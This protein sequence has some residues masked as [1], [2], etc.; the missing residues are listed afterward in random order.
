MAR[1]HPNAL[2][3]LNSLSKH[4]S[5][6]RVNYH[7]LEFES[8]ISQIGKKVNFL[9]LN[10]IFQPVEFLDK[11]SN[12]WYRQ[13]PDYLRVPFG[14]RGDLYK[15]N[16]RYLNWSRTKILLGRCASVFRVV[17]WWC[18]KAS[19]LR[20]HL[21]ENEDVV[22]RSN[23]LN[24]PEIPCV[25]NYRMDLLLIYCPKPKG[26][27]DDSQWRKPLIAQS[28]LHQAAGTL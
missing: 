17:C 11:W 21:K 25:F 10:D 9:Y 5:Q 27:I 15:K 6:M 8:H 20:C 24:Q 12:Y 7:V 13:S 28:A 26:L 14:G 18:D 22:C 1:L 23:I 2:V 16:R 3:E 4:S 19:V